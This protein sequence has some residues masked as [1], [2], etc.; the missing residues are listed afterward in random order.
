MSALL[1]A[2]LG[3]RSDFA[4]VL[5]GAG[6]VLIIRILAS[7]VG[8]ASVILLARWMASNLSLEG[9]LAQKCLVQDVFVHIEL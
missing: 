1:C 4:T 6:L 5:R 8:Y 7:A 2:I 9:G 3:E